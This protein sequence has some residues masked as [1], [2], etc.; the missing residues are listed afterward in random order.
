MGTVIIGSEQ[1]LPGCI[2]APVL[3]QEVIRACSEG[4]NLKEPVMRFLSTLAEF[5]QT[6]VTLDS[7]AMKLF[8]LRLG[9]FNMNNDDLKKALSF[10]AKKVKEELDAQKLAQP[11]VNPKKDDHDSEDRQ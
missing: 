5:A 7:H 3:L 1:D 9:L 6:A 2:K 4:N 11:A 10:E 8:A